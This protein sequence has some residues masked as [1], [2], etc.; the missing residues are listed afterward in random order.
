MDFDRA[1]TF[2]EEPTERQ[3]EWVAFEKELMAEMADFMVCVLCSHLCP[4]L[5]SF[6]GSLEQKQDFGKRRV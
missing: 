3:K 5:T 1:Q 4:L 2:N 6:V